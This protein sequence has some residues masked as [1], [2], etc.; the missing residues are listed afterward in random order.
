MVVLSLFDGISCG[1]V[2]L[3]RAGIKVDKYYASEIDKYAIKVS[4]DNYSDIIRIGDVTR[5]NYRDGI[6]YTEKGEFNV[7]KIDLLIGGSPCQSFSQSGDGSG[8]DG[9]SKLFWEYARIRHQVNPTF[10][11]LENVKMRKEWKD[12]I[13]GAVGNEP[14][15][16]NS[17]RVSAQNRVRNYWTNIP[18]VEQPEDMGINLIDIIEDGIVDRDKA[19]T[20]T[21]TYRNNPQLYEYTAQKRKQIVFLDRSKSY[22]IDANY[23]KGGNPDQYFNKSRRQLVFVQDDGSDIVYYRKLT[24]VECE[25]LQNLPDG[26]TSAVS[27]TQRYKALGNGWNVNTITHILKY[28]PV[29]VVEISKAA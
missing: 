6:L 4:E 17:A 1:R 16:I 19:L 11:L 18:G 23:W 2:A 10:Y 8:F 28:I 12:I 25:R 14:I 21:S 9:K 13:T 20:L 5:V 27:N 3:E 22:C 15:E 26:F 29:N 24:P 7:G